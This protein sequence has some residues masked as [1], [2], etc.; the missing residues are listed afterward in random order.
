MES[1]VADLSAPNLPPLV[2][3]PAPIHAQLDGALHDLLVGLEEAS[4]AA[5]YVGA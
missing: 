2:I 5:E 4:P 1:L 3:G